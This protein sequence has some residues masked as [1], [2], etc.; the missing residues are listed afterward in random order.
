VVALWTKRYNGP[1]NSNDV[2][3]AIGVDSRGTV[4]VTGYS[5][6]GASGYDFATVAYAPDGTPLST[7][8]YNGP[9]NGD[10]IVETRSCLAIG[11]DDAVYVAGTSLGPNASPAYPDSVFTIV[12]YLPWPGIQF[13]DIAATPTGCR[14][15]INTPTNLAYR[16]EAS[17]NLLNWTMLNTFSNLATPSIQYTDQAATLL[18]R[19]FY[20]AVAT[21]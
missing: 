16:L 8:R 11:R 9:G 21:P 13:S 3:R 6:G 17:T 15:T 2:A 14:F 12:K 10:D 5:W 19:R 18:R 20:R 4:Y 7:N 1:G